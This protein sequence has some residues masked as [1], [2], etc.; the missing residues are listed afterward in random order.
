MFDHPRSSVSRSTD[1]MRDRLRAIGLFCEM[2]AWKVSFFVPTAGEG[3][4]DPFAAYRASSHC[5]CRRSDVM[6]AIPHAL[7]FEIVGPSR[8]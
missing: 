1:C 5:R 7:R 4:R 2:I 6:E 3:P 8:A